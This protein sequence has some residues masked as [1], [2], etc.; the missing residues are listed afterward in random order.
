MHTKWESFHFSTDLR[1]SL[2]YI[3][4]TSLVPSIDNTN[5]LT[6]FIPDRF[7]LLLMDINLAAHSG[8]SLIL[9]LQTAKRQMVSIFL[10][11]DECFGNLEMVPPLGIATNSRT[12]RFVNTAVCVDKSDW[13]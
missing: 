10:F 4:T 2:R 8:L 13:G 5:S 1:L 6:D 3:Q 9:V 11:A 12:V 7:L